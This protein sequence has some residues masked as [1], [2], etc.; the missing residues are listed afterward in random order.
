MLIFNIKLCIEGES[1]TE[2]KENAAKSLLAII[3]KEFPECIPNNF[4][5]LRNIYNSYTCSFY[6]LDYIIN[7][8]DYNPIE[9][10]QKRCML[11]RVPLPNYNLKTIE[12][13]IQREVY[14]I[15]RRVLYLIGIGKCSR[16]RLA[17]CKA[18]N[19]LYLKLKK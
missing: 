10:L 13:T 5:E 2:A 16:R 7:C 17:K 1:K 6:N 11:L 18:V 19:N 12:S 15:L 8:N 9:L 14:F 4:N 3:I